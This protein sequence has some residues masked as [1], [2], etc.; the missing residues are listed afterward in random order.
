M[1][2]KLNCTPLFE[3]Y[4]SALNDTEHDIIIMRGGTSSSKTFCIL[5]GFII[6]L[7]SKKD[8]KIHIL[9]KEL[10]TLRDTTLIDF[11]ELLNI[12]NIYKLIHFN[13]SNLVFRN[14]GLNNTI[15]F[16]GLEESNKIRGIS[17]NYI[18]LNECNKFSYEEFQQ[19]YLRMRNKNVNE[20][21]RNKMVLD[22]NPSEPYS[23]VRALENHP[24]ALLITSTYRDNTLLD[25]DTIKRIEDLQFTDPEKWSWLGLGEYCIPEALVFKNVTEY[26]KLPDNVEFQKFVGL[27]FG[28]SNDPTAISLCHVS[29]KRK[30]IYID[31][32]AYQGGLL[33]TD[34]LKII[35]DAGISE[36]NIV[37]DSAS[38]K[39]IKELSN[40]GLRRIVGANKGVDSVISS[41]QKLKEY[42]IFINKNSQNLRFEFQNYVWKKNNNNQILNVI[43]NGQADHLIDSVRYVALNFLNK[44]QP[45]FNMTIFKK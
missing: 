8:L 14:R 44:K 28:F 36:L 24:S 2:L 12:D 1:N 18:Y 26:E 4:W 27:D 43:E 15:K 30:E 5:Q 31:E 37:A 10:T 23:W 21:L 11:N 41:I 32:I 34:I 39:D 17:S 16:Q 25:D 45:E 13:K 9:R 35:K 20:G 19:L 40:Y 42:K 29:E 6:Y 33:N 38:P 7:F 22:W 3:K